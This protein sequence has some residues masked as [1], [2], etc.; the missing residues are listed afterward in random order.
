M[1]RRSASVVIPVQALARK[2][3]IRQRGDLV[4]KLRDLLE[5]AVELL[6]AELLRPAGSCGRLL[7]QRRGVGAE[8][9][10]MGS[11]LPA[12]LRLDL[13]PDIDDDGHSSCSPMLAAH[14][15]AAV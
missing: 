13:R 14:P 15:R 12:Q 2:R 10:T 1:R 3:F 11:G 9:D 8:I 7:E 5:R 6:L 4:R